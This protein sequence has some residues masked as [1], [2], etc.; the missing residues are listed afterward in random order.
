MS[1]TTENAESR[2]ESQKVIGIP[3][4]EQGLSEILP[5]PMLRFV[6]SHAGRL[7]DR[8]ARFTKSMGRDPDL[9]DPSLTDKDKEI[10]LAAAKAWMAVDS[11]ILST[12]YLAG[13]VRGMYEFAVWS[14]L[15]TAVN[16][17]MWEDISDGIDED[18][19]DERDFAMEVQEK[20]KEVEV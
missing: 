13:Y 12:S 5:E 17:S 4:E 7:G 2:M 10:I 3:L 9:S 16:G 6:M 11:S 8:F 14:N 20:D 1:Q 15:T 18:K 19:D